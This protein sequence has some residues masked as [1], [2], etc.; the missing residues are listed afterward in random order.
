M[1]LK[2]YYHPFSSFCQKVLVALYEN[3]AAFER[4]IVDLGDPEQSEALRRLWP[5]RKFPVLRDEERGLTIPESSVI[6][7]YVERHHPGRA[8]LIPDDGD[9]ALRV[10]ALDRIF[11]NYVSMS[12]TKVVVDR[13]RPEGRRDPQGV[14]EARALIESAYG[15]LDSELPAGGWAAGEAF[16]LADCAAA[17]ALFY[18]NIVVPFGRHSNLAAYYQRLLER[19]S[20]ARAV[21]EA[22]PY[23]HLFPLEWPASYG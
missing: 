13:I 14:E 22:R 23:R 15:L 19:P 17:P 11:D 12:V 9:L 16:T 3:G 2:L 18:S 6:V 1:A 7:A 10:D 20:F 4:E 5:L 8:K 21:D